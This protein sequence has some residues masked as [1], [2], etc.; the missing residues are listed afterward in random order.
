MSENTAICN[1]DSWPGETNRAPGNYPGAMPGETDKVPEIL[2][3]T[4][5][6]DEKCPL[7]DCYGPHVCLG[8]DT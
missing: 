4:V 6:K 7:C 8:S 3:P 2:G 5:F 1:N